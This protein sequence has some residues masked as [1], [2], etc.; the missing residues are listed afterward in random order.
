MPVSLELKVWGFISWKDELLKFSVR[1]DWATTRSGV[2]G[3][4]LFDLFC[5]ILGFSDFDGLSTVT[6]LTRPGVVS[7]IFVVFLVAAVSVLEASHGQILAY[8]SWIEFAEFSWKFRIFRFSNGDYFI[9]PCCVYRWFRGYSR[10]FWM[11]EC[12]FWMA[13]TDWFSLILVAFMGPIFLR[14]FKNIF[15][16]GHLCKPPSLATKNARNRLKA[17]NSLLDQLAQIGA[18]W[19]IVL[20]YKTTLTKW[21]ISTSHCLQEPSLQ[22]ISICGDQSADH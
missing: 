17:T 15:V 16:G 11:L 7:I 6:G 4:N 14:I 5:Q 10:C 3:R 19:R 12:Q 9:S 22:A 2:F 20:L 1:T 21:T 13:F 8:L 18:G